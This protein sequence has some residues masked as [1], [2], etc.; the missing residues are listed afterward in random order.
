MRTL[1]VIAIDWSGARSEGKLRGIW[2]SAIRD[3]EIVED[4]GGWSRR[5]AADFVAS[6]PPPFVAGFDFSFGLPAWFAQQLGLATIDD[7]WACATGHAESW[8]T[9][10]PPFW[11]RKCVLPPEQQYRACEVALRGA[12]YQP[13]SVFQLVGNGQV[14]A[15]SVRGMPHLARLRADGVAVWPF[16][17]PSDRLAIEIYPTSAAPRLSRA[18][19][20]RRSQPPRARRTRVRPCDVGVPRTVRR[21][22]ARDRRGHA[23][24]GRSVGAGRYFAQYYLDLSASMIAGTTLWTSPTMPRSATEKIGASPSLFTAMMLSLFFM[25][26]RCCVAPEMPS[27]M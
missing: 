3:G 4:R 1:T 19:L 27:A 26:T 12:G 22:A 8:L 15:G 14:G 11:N 17:G 16:D 18:R 10:H 13:K 9:P 6:T 2:V 24:R 5:E 23:H 7:V 21:V 25:P 20:P